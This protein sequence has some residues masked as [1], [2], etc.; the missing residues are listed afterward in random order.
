MYYEA[1]KCCKEVYETNIDL[2]TTEFNIT[3][4]VIKD[5]EYQVLAIAGTNEPEDWFE[6][7]NFTSFLGIKTAAYKAAF[8]IANNR[9]FIRQRAE[10]SSSPLIVAGHSKAGATAIAFMKLFYV[11]KI[12]C[13]SYPGFIN[14]SHCIA[15]APARCL[16]YWTDRKMENTAIFTDPDDPVSFVGR[17]SFGHPVCEHIKSENNYFGFKIG[18]H[19]IDNWVR[20]TQNMLI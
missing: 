5:K 12:V 1:A 20:Y 19:D 15:F 6:N 3:R 7:L 2:G 18:D 13:P 17:I 9:Y 8:E 16:R 14:P 11:S 4:H 10:S